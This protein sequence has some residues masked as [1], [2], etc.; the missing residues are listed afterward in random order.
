[1]TSKN[2]L[3]IWIQAAEKLQKILLNNDDDV[4]QTMMIAIELRASYI[5]GKIDGV[6]E[7]NNGAR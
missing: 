2:D 6:G 4:F 7:W 3:E 5:K 1:M